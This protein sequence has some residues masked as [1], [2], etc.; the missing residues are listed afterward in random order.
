MSDSDLSSR[1]FTLLMWAEERGNLEK[2][3]KRERTG[4][5]ISIFLL[6]IKTHFLTKQRHPLPC[7]MFVFF[8]FFTK[9]DLILKKQQQP[10][11]FFFI[12]YANIFTGLRSFAIQ[13]PYYSFSFSLLLNPSRRP[14]PPPPSFST[15]YISSLFR[16]YVW[17]IVEGVPLL[18][19]SRP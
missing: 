3:V 1:G 7:K 6:F 8:F 5:F 11:T 19:S 13:F 18:L 14:P 9:T 10:K 15:P 4:I 17:L 16:R 12:G 2:H